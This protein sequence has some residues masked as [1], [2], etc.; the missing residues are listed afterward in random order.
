VIRPQDL[1]VAL[2][3]P[4]NSL[5][6]LPLLIIQFCHA[7]KTYYIIFYRGRTVL[8]ELVREINEE[9]TLENLNLLALSNSENKVEIYNEFSQDLETLEDKGLNQELK[10]CLYFILIVYFRRKQILPSQEN[11]FQLARFNGGRIQRKTQ[12]K[13]LVDGAKRLGLPYQIQKKLTCEK[14][15]AITDHSHWQTSSSSGSEEPKRHVPNLCEALRQERRFRNFEESII[16]TIVDK[17]TSE[18]GWIVLYEPKKQ[19]NLRQEKLTSDLLNSQRVSK[20]RIHSQKSQSVQGPIALPCKETYSSAPITLPVKKSV[21]SQAEIRFNS[22][23]M[24]SLALVPYKSPQNMLTDLSQR[25]GKLINQRIETRTNFIPKVINH[26]FVHPKVQ[27]ILNGSLLQLLA[28][29]NSYNIQQTPKIIKVWAKP[30]Q[31]TKQTNIVAVER[32]PQNSSL[33]LIPLPKLQRGRFLIFGKNYSQTH[34]NLDLLKTIKNN[35]IR[36]LPQPKSITTVS[37]VKKSNSSFRILSKIIDISSQRTFSVHEDLNKNLLNVQLEFFRGLCEPVTF[38]KKLPMTC[39]NRIICAHYQNWVSTKFET[40]NPLVFKAKSQRPLA[41]TYEKMPQLTYQKISTIT[42]V[43]TLSLTYEKRRPLALTYNKPKIQALS[44]EKIYALPYE[45]LKAITYERI[46]ALPYQK[47]LALKCEK[48]LAI[49]NGESLDI[50]PKCNQEIMNIYEVFAPKCL[51]Y[52]RILGSSEKANIDNEETDSDSDDLSISEDIT[53]SSES[54]EDALGSLADQ[55]SL[56]ES[57]VDKELGRGT[58]LEYSLEQSSE[59]ITSFKSQGKSEIYISQNADYEKIIEVAH[60]K[61]LD[62]VVIIED[63]EDNDFEEIH[64]EDL[65][66]IETK[67]EKEAQ[68]IDEIDFE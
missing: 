11:R 15:L 12:L 23:K 53:L 54:N 22:K 10:Q 6:P 14:K 67:I 36:A 58:L 24:E 46:P 35:P 13:A 40:N 9:N 61:E 32:V 21:I 4:H 48:I 68:G 17:N 18:N 39:L 56:E 26:C 41:L 63:D 30:S 38:S 37:L 27:T 57:F 33:R 34:S 65:M 31:E 3:S 8:V 43:K 16:Q 25:L 5:N 29:Y 20:G 47:I 19:Q 45:K 7:N 1:Q 66:I 64:D 50:I 51:D 2:P 55:E 52:L 44:Y 28:K 49:T 42:Y 60:E 62:E 59:F